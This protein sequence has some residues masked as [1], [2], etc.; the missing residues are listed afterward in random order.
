MSKRNALLGLA[1]AGLITSACGTSTA[2][3]ARDAVAQTPKRAALTLPADPV[4]RA[5][6]CSGA[7]LAVA[8]LQP[9]FE[10]NGVSEDEM[11]RVMHPVYVD[12]G[13]SGRIEQARLELAGNKSPIKAAEFRKNGKAEAT[14]VACEEV[15]PAIRAGAFKALP[16][17]DAQ[18]RI[19][20]VATAG[21]L[22]QTYQATE[23][24]RSERLPA[25]ARLMEQLTEPV[26]ADFERQGVTD[27]ELMNAELRAV[28]ART[29]RSGPPGEVMTA[30]LAR[31]GAESRT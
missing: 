1:A 7:Y 19:A 10:K 17:E 20:C 9:G 11:N 16:T 31:F 15:Y 18:A 26:F 14:I 29:M 28:L 25:I 21:A 27:V 13:A 5:A 30:C 8:Q 4:E 2:E 22:V 24:V 23:E 6:T 3:P 12:A